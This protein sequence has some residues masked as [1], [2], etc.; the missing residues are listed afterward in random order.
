MK[1]EHEKPVEILLRTKFNQN[2]FNC[3][4]N[5]CRAKLQSEKR[6]LKYFSIHFMMVVDVWMEEEAETAGEEKKITHPC[7]YVGIE[8]F[9]RLMN[10]G[11][12]S[13]AGLRWKIYEIGKGNER[14]ATLILNGCPLMFCVQYHVLYSVRHK[15]SCCCACSCSCSTKPTNDACVE[16][17]SVE[18]KARQHNDFNL[19]QCPAID[20]RNIKS[21]LKGT[22]H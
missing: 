14:E 17:I 19:V 7:C 4:I 10:Y 6:E 15:F 9:A 8:W 12:S 2:I 1:N 3:A 20:I 11:S 18:Y 13:L 16:E 21:V 5:H 22:T